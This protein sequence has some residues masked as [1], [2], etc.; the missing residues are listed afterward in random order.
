MKKKKIGPYID[1]TD[2]WVFKFIKF[3][4]KEIAKASG[5]NRNL[6]MAGLVTKF[7]VTHKDDT[8]TLW[9]WFHDKPTGPQFNTLSC[10]GIEIRKYMEN[11]LY[12]SQSFNYVTG[13]RHIK[14]LT[15]THRY[16]VFTEKAKVKA[17]VLEVYNE[18]KISRSG[19][20]M[21]AYKKRRKYG[22]L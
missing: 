7:C 5:K 18:V 17:L 4:V 22:P 12:I 8:S 15:P 3:V 11:K 2:T 10:Y 21:K 9:D 1:Y 16:P 6:I 14:P 13:M 20:S 19:A